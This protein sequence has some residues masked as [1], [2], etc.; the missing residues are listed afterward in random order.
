MHA[1]V[2]AMTNKNL[3]LLYHYADNI[4]TK[5]IYIFISTFMILVT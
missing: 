4:A 2:A 5:K 1:K 3:C